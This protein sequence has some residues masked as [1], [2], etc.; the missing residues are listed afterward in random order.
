MADC[1]DILIAGKVSIPLLNIVINLWKGVPMD[2]AD[3]IRD[4]Y[5]KY[6][7]AQRTGD[8]EA[9][10]SLYTNDAKLI[11]P[12]QAP[13]TG[14]AEIE[15]YYEGQGSSGVEMDLGHIE[16]AANLA[17]VTGLGHWDADGQRRHVAFL[18]V[19]RRE[20][21]GWQIAACMWNSPDGFVLA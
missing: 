12:G 20:K 2:A 15:N 4:L 10:A 6:L 3:E 8:S 7:D 5:R 9:V 13:L 16:V 21:D 1:L 17:W 19:W 14:R 18:D 11:P